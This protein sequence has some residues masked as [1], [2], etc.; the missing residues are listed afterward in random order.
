MSH[1]PTNH[2]LRPLYRVLAGLTGLYVLAFGI[3]GVIEAA[4]TDLFGNPSVHALGLRTNMAFAILSVITGVVVLGVTV[5]GRNMDY[6]VNQWA[7]YGF[8]GVGLI[9][10]ALLQTDLNIL[11]FSIATCIVSFV[12]GLLLLTAALYSKVG[13]DDDVAAERAFAQRRSH[14][15][16]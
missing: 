2:P 16:G 13:S 12:I 14:A 11:N 9:M 8:L 4:G 6:L 5:I 15:R 10:L 3:V 7:G 1:T